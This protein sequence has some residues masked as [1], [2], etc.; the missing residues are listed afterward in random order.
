MVDRS[1]VVRWLR[2]GLSF[3]LLLQVLLPTPMVAQSNPPVFLPLIGQGSR[4]VDSVDL[5]RTQIAAR[6][7]AQW[8][9]LTELDIVIIDQGDDW[10][11][12]VVDDEQ[13]ATL[14]RLRYN[15]T[16][17]DK[18]QS[19]V[20]A[21]GNATMSAAWQP[22]FAAAAAVEAQAANAASTAARTTSRSLLASLTS[23]QTEW[24]TV[25]ASV[26]SDN[27]GLTDDQEAMWCTSPVQADS[28]FDGVNDGAEVAALKAWM[29]NERAGPPSSGKP[30]QGWPHQKENCFDD[31][32]DSVPDLAESLELGLNPGRESTDRDKFD[33]GQE[34]F[35]ITYCTGQGGFCS[36]GPLP[37]NE[38]WG[39]I[40]AEMPSWVKA[41]GNHPLVAA[42]P[43]PEIDVV[44][45]SLKVETVTTITTDNVITE[46]TEKSYSTAKT[47]GTSTSVANTET[48]NEWQETSIATMQ[49]IQAT[50]LNPEFS[51]NGG[52]I[53]AAGA[54]WD[55]AKFAGAAG[56]AL[57]VVATLGGCAIPAAIGGAAIALGDVIVNYKES[58]QSQHEFE[59][60][61][62]EIQNLK[63]QQSRCV[64][65]CVNNTG[66][67]ADSHEVQV[68]QN[69]VI[70]SQDISSGN[71]RAIGMEG[72]STP[73]IRQFTQLSYP[74]K[75]V[76]TT[77]NTSTQG[78]SWGGSQ[79]TTNTQYEEHTVTNGEAFL[80][81][82]SWGTAVAENSA[83]AADLT[84]TYQVR[85]SGTEYARE[86]GNLAFNIYIGDDPNPTHTYF[87][88]PDIGGAGKFQNFMP[89]AQH[90]YTSSPIPLSL[91]Q[92]K[93][94][95]LGGP[96]RI[97]VEDFTYGIDE[98]FYQDAANAGVLIALEDGTA[99]GDE[100]IDTYLIPTWGNE[101]VLQVLARY[102]PNETDA[103]G[104]LT[105]IWTPEYRSDTPAWCQSPRRPT[106]L[107]SRVVWCKH[108]LSTADWWNIYT[109]GLGDGSEGLQS[110]RAMPGSVALFR[111]N[112]D[113]DL[114]G[115]SDRSEVRLGTDP[116][117]ASSFPRPELIAGLHRIQNGNRVTATL[118]LLNTGL[119]DAYGVEAIMVAPD[120]SISITNNTVGGS[121]RVRAQ[122]QVIVGSRIMLQSPLPAPWL[123][124]NHARP[125]TAGY[126][127][128]NVDR[129]YTLTVQC[130][131][132]GGCSVGAGDWSLHWNDGSGASGTLRFDQTYAAPTFLPLGAHGLTLALHS[133]TVGNGDSFTIAAR[134]PRDTFQY[135]IN[136]TPHSEPLVMVSYNDPQGNHR[137]VL[138]A[139]AM[140]LAAPTDNLQT[141]AGTMLTDVGVELVTHQAFAPGTNQVELLINNPAPAT[142]QNAN[143][144][145]EFINISGTVVAE[146]PTQVTLLPGPTYVPVS[147]TSSSFNPPY[148]STEDYIVLAF[149]TDYEGNILDTAGRPLSSFQVDPVPAL[150]GEAITWNFGTLA[151]GTVAKYALPLANTGFG[152]LYTY[153]APQ[154]GVSLVRNAR[155]VG[156]ADLVD[157]ELLLNTADL[158]VGAYDQTLTLHTSDPARPT[159]A[160]R[161]TGQ[162]AAATGDLPGGVVSRPLD[163]AVTVPAGH[164]QGD[165]F[166]FSHSLGPD[167]QS[168]HPVRV[169][170]QAGSTL[171]GVGRYATDFGA[172]TAS[173]EM[174]GDGRDG[175]MPG[176]GNLDNDQGFAAGNV[177]GTAGATT[178]SVI[179]RRAV[180]RINPGDVVLIHQTRGSGAGQWELN[181][182]V[183]DL[184]G[185]GTLTLQKPLA[186]NYVTNTGAERA[187]ILRVPQYTDCPVT[188]TVTPLAAWNGDWGGIFAV[189]C[190]NGLNVTGTISV[191]GYGFRGGAG[192]IGGNPSSQRHGYQGESRFGSGGQSQSSN[193][194]GGG[195]GRADV[196]A[197]DG[198]GGGGGGS[199]ATNGQNGTIDSI[200]PKQDYGRGA[201][202][203]V[204]DSALLSANFGGAGGGGGT[205][206]DSSTY[207]GK[208]G[209]SGGFIFISAM[210]IVGTGRLDASGSPGNSG[211]PVGKDG[212]GGGGG[213]AG[214]SIKITMG[215]GNIG[216]MWAVGG[217]GA[218]KVQQSGIGGN[219]GTGRIQ[220]D[221]CNNPPGTTN[222]PASTQ[223]LDCHIVEQVE[224][225]PYTS[226][227]LNLPAAGPQSYGVQF[228]R[229]L[230]F[231]AAGEQQT[232]V[233]VPAS[234]VSNA[235]L[236]LLVSG[237]GSGSLTAQLDIGNDGVWDCV[238]TQT[239]SNAAQL[240]CPTLADAINAYWAT[241]GAPTTGTLDLPIRLAL[242][243]PAQ[244][245]LTNLQLTS[246][247]STVRHVRLPA[248]NYTQ[249]LLDFTAGN[250][251]PVVA[252][253]DIGDN[254]SIDW[255]TPAAV[256]A[257]ARWTTGNLA[258][259][260]NAYLTSKSGDVLVP[261][262]F[263]V[264]PSGA[265][266]LNA[267]TAQQSAQVDLTVDAPIVGD[268]AVSAASVDYEQGELV[269]LSA[270]I[271]NATGSA[272]G[273]VT[274][275]FFA[276]AAGWGDWYLG[277]ELINNIPAGGSVTVHAQWN[278]TG[279]SGTLPVSV[280]V[281]PYGRVAETDF[282]NNRQSTTATVSGPDVPETELADQTIN[283]AS[284]PTKRA[285]DPSFGISATATSGLP[286]SFVSQ[287][288]L[289]CT[290]N[291]NLVTLNAAGTCT[292]RAEQAG[293]ANFR[294]APPV[295]RS[296]TVQG[297]AAPPKSIQTIDFAPLGDR[298]MGEP[299]FALH[300][301]A[302][303]GL[304]VAFQS[305]TTEICT[306]SGTM[307]TLVATGTC[308]IQAD[309]TGDDNFL[310][311]LSVSRSFMVD[312]QSQE[313]QFGLLADVTMAQSPVGL[314]V[315]ASSGLLV[316]LSSL[317]LEICTV[318]N[319]E[320]SLI[321]PGICA[322]RADQNGNERYHAAEPVSRSFLIQK[323]TQRIN[324]IV[325]DQWLAQSPVS[326]SATASSGLPVRFATATPDVCTVNG[327]QV[328]LLEQGYCTILAEQ[329]GDDQFAAA[330]SVQREF[331]VIGDSVDP[332]AQFITFAQLPS[333]TI[334]ETFVL[335]ATASSGLPVS[336]STQ[337]HDVCTL[338]D[339]TVSLVG[340]GYCEIE[341][342]QPGNEQYQPAPVVKQT[343]S[344]TDPTK[345]DQTITFEPIAVWNIGD[346]PFEL[347]A[348]ASSGLFVAFQSETLSICMVSGEIV[349]P[350]APGN[351]II[352]ALQNGNDDYN[353]APLVVR[354]IRLENDSLVEPPPPPTFRVFLPRISR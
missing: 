246:A 200:H 343:F 323:A 288:P 225:V 209:T 96:I 266:N 28:D 145:L 15:P 198:G 175:V 124:A 31:D 332:E 239:V 243:K 107:P 312:K 219:G 110:T 99:D 338:T 170:D 301:T 214:G 197:G 293:N 252:A 182:A 199:H 133:G 250:S 177:S 169:Y 222:P 303:S 77:T 54:G 120:D 244:I 213:G 274:A 189:M 21:A 230:N 30:F 210:N 2:L 226:A 265:L 10:A 202:A 156:A 47:E 203:I 151:Q 216:G 101:T 305:Q 80:S 316:S 167:P 264:S 140:S 185:T 34:L 192:G 71:N 277:S 52:Q 228:G 122:Q 130:G 268:G 211:A 65:S 234:M 84:F 61:N 317:T 262:R 164:N 29:N 271:R 56:L 116:R 17:T 60:L 14:A 281:N 180:Q 336:Y 166:E 302:T 149:L 245:L 300:A 139:G 253:V 40:F 173:A 231:A 64:D 291:G 75:F 63:H 285:D 294:A 43:V 159:V 81:E 282:A 205:D 251:G 187:Q 269:P 275:A 154:V 103:N 42:F 318:N 304:P 212:G 121:G 351:C 7:S 196:D 150:S 136:R 102:F 24:L 95:D 112:Q 195:G 4:S 76:P 335:T 233:R 344:V 261:I 88:A 128:G 41:P 162:I 70:E 183:N 39:I 348:V 109:D 94:I 138:P 115:F 137:F 235:S 352:T 347:V 339:A 35:G 135:T 220:I 190:S 238:H 330:P 320:I 279:F 256:S 326:L 242:S 171:H 299:A 270:I 350:L 79:T 331:R 111:F 237:A 241:Q 55:V 27:D 329:P 62:Q 85:N 259:I 6:T 296:F 152:R 108:S 204:G 13:L 311:A 22:L 36:Y 163:V 236:E 72:Q 324:F 69:A 91:E 49:E 342:R 292:I 254:G 297:T 314:N 232:V 188:G 74:Q 322:I 57:C 9:A 126:Y 158:P 53:S 206:D 174:F 334:R 26:D 48:W 354:T 319:Q 104:M 181:K 257:P 93:R 1:I 255:S 67:I 131:N 307:V 249:F 258:T 92:M 33:D 118:S 247:A 310:A 143:L 218:P 100:T 19:L 315:S 349:Q 86:I 37:R 306:I 153:L 172:G 119:Y 290:V 287:T 117:E 272:S 176:S 8:Q 179:D 23:E 59:Q 97:V 223:K 337:T 83:H 229:K 105:A 217:T 263:F 346:G 90:Q 11:L 283:F 289:V 207:G 191:N 227:R 44:A 146:V 38:D 58:Q 325:S 113:S 168:L 308:T 114:D 5:Y 160:V 215:T 298:T 127:T 273:P 221:H 201:T 78:K 208:G 20:A 193:D 340:I 267:Y 132:P 129:T 328:T 345:L 295:T 82:E 50:R 260:L 18:I 141:L 286:V 240:A 106:D 3:A 165:W 155:T 194:I 353:P 184:T 144:F 309:Q 16:Q 134:T 278:T 341:A 32:H 321:A 123:Q 45:S 51:G 248:Q 333:R 87:V 12:V 280:V 157:Y 276:H 98:L 224:T 313:I 147:F 178:I 66:Q 142:L 46:G 148:K 186:Y 73:Y 68:Y 161:L 89:N 125:A 25:A 327:A 284:L